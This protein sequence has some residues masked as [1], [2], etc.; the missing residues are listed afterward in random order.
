M[1]TI[2]LE[3]DRSPMDTEMTELSLLLP[4]WQLAELEKF[5]Q[6][7]GLTLGQVLRRLINA[8][9]QEP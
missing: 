6:D 8:F 7:Q 1:R 5:A 3:Q 4:K 9:L 2:T